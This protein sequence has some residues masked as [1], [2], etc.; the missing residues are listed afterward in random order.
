MNLTPEAFAAA[1]EKRRF[2]ASPE[3]TMACYLAERL[4]AVLKERG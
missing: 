4:D 1:F 3:V 2:V